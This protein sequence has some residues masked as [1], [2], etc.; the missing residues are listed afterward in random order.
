MGVKSKILRS[1]A[2]TRVSAA[3]TDRGA[4]TDERGFAVA[5]LRNLTQFEIGYIEIK[6]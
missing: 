4:H 2:L 6:P 1:R 3:A 5:W